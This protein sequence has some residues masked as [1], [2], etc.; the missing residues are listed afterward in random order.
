MVKNREKHPFGRT[1][2]RVSAIIEKNILCGK[3]FGWG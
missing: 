1:L 2:V 3:A